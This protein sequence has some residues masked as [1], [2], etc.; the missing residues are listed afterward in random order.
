MIIVHCDV[1]LAVLR[2]SDQV[3]F[4]G[5]Q[6]KFITK[7]YILFKIKITFNMF[8][9]PFFQKSHIDK[10]K[11]W[12]YLEK[13]IVKSTQFWRNGM[14]SFWKWYTDGWV[15]GWIESNFLGSA[16]T[17]SRTILAKVIPLLKV[18]SLKAKSYRV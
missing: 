5:E 11:N 3:I 10:F 6:V 15:I 14:L 9:R 13:I 17:Y 16:G 4:Y 1:T 2:P 12:V 18:Q 7:P 8:N